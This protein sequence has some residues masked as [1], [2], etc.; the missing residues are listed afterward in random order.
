MLTKWST[1]RPWAS[2]LK[3]NSLDH[4]KLKSKLEERRALDLVMG[5][6]QM[7]AEEV[8]LNEV[9]KRKLTSKIAI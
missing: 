8:N 3:Q 4:T 5:H 6:Q 9:V 1:K 7:F 2:F